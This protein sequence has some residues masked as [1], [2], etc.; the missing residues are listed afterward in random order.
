MFTLRHEDLV[1]APVELDRD[2][3][4][5][6]AIEWSDRL[7]DFLVRGFDTGIDPKTVGVWRDDLTDVQVAAVVDRAGELMQEL[8]YLD[9]KERAAT[10]GRG[11]R[12]LTRASQRLLG[13][14]RTERRPPAAS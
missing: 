5:F 6:M 9:E 1:A 8:G 12:R 3:C 11:S 13:A 7:D 10:G 14:V 2:L 4:Q